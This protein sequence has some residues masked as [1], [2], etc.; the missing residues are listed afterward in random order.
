[1][2][3]RRGIKGQQCYCMNEGV[4]KILMYSI[5]FDYPENLKQIT[6]EVYENLPGLF[7]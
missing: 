2:I 5:K 6:P 3:L 1:M 4:I 7:V